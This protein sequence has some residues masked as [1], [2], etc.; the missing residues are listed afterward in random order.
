[1]LVGRLS[2]RQHT[3]NGKNILN[4]EISSVFTVRLSHALDFHVYVHT[5]ASQ[6]YTRVSVYLNKK[7]TMAWIQRVQP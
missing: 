3:N 7:Y 6:A 4:F 1:M 5:Y 2:F